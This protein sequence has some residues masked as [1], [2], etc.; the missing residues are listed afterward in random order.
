MM[1]KKTKKTKTR[2]MMTKTKTTYMEQVASSN[3]SSELNSGGPWFESLSEH[4]KCD[5]VWSWFFEASHAKVVPEISSWRI[6]STY[7][8]VNYVL[9]SKYWSLQ[10]LSY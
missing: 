4:N 6:L 5:L 8:P 2:M 7:L 3:K 10:S 1:T 9:S